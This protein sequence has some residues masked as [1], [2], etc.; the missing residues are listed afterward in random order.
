MPPVPDGRR[1]ITHTHTHTHTDIHTDTQTHTDRQ[2]DTHTHTHTQTDIQTDRQ[3]D[4]HIQRQKDRHTYKD[5]Q[6]YTQKSDFMMGVIDLHGLSN[7]VL[8]LGVLLALLVFLLSSLLFLAQQANVLLEPL[9]LSAKR[10]PACEGEQN[11][12]F[13]KR[14]RKNTAGI[15]SSVNQ[16]S[17]LRERER[18]RERKHQEKTRA[19]E[20][21][22]IT[23]HHQ[24]RTVPLSENREELAAWRRGE[25]HRR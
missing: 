1:D 6:T 10:R 16:A 12:G 23:T 2:T 25:L 22:V 20:N 4:T 15:R 19:H 24:H 8:G 14:A 7:R 18:M 5:R 13:H 17:A 11:L 9:S 21:I 3:T